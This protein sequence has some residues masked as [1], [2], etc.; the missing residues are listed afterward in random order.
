MI[1]LTEFRCPRNEKIKN[2]H[3]V[4]TPIAKKSPQPGRGHDRGGGGGVDNYPATTIATSKTTDH[5]RR[6]CHL[7]TRAYKG[8]S[9]PLTRVKQ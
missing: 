8:Q 2:P 7:T 9:G 3:K 5:Q 6:D 1:I 4:T